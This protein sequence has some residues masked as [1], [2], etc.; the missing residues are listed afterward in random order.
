M[1]IIGD[2]YLCG[3]CGYLFERVVNKRPAENKQNDPS[4]SG[5]HTTSDQLRC[6]QCFKHVN[7]RLKDEI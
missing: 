6:P 3:F 4:R 1:R 5:R 2:R 7:Q